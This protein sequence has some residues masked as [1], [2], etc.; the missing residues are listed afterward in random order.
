VDLGRQE[1]QKLT[2]G[3]N[4]LVVAG[5]IEN[6][7]SW[8]VEIK[9]RKLVYRVVASNRMVDVWSAKIP[10]DKDFPLARLLYESTIS[11]LVERTNWPDSG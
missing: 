10:T 5:A 9:K 3:V 2:P 8:G 11:C 7:I 6:N 1:K 4:E